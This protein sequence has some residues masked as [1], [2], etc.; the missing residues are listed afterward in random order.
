MTAPY[1]DSFIKMTS[2]AV[3]P[4]VSVAVN[5]ISQFRSPGIVPWNVRVFW[6]KVSQFSKASPFF[7][8]AE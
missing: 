1:L 5:L 7:K 4:D 8:V 6:L 3:A 2:L